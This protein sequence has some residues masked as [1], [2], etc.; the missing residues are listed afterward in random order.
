VLEIAADS[1]ARDAGGQCTGTD[2]RDAARPSGPACDSGAFEFVP[3]PVVQATPTPAPTATPVVT[4]TP[5]PTPAPT[6]GYHKTVVVAKVSGTVKVKLPGTSTYV[7][8]DVTQGIPLKSTVDVR[9]GKVQLTSVPKAGGQPETAVFYDGIFKVTQVGKITNLTLVEALA[10]CPKRAAHA[11][12][13]KPKTRRLW[14][15]G[16]GNFR[17]TGNYSAA[18]IRG[19]TWLVQDSCAATLTKVTQGVVS[20]RDNVKHRTFLVK[21]HHQYLA[22]P[23]R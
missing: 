8:L 12:A 16:K 11:A 3:A 20:V 19:T 14:G 5:S 1:V 23:K 10:P 6:P 2:Q 9:H 7:D 13:K 21:A 18:T 15:S 17:T 4:P 22:G